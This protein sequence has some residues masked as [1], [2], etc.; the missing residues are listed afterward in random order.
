MSVNIYDL[1]G[2]IEKKNLEKIKNFV[3]EVFKK[4]GFLSNRYD[5]S[6]VLVDDLKI[7]E[8]NNKYRNKDNPTDVLSFYLGKD[9]K[10]RII[11]EIYISIDTARV[12]ALENK[13]DLLDE[14][15]FLSLHGVLHILGFDH[16]TEED[17][18]K[19]EKETAKLIV[20]WRQ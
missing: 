17:Y 5:L 18:E 10:G 20:L 13:K 8:L 6:I 16:E 15:A 19:M 4:E 2:G 3:K 1:Y 12:Q 14:L 9:P 7:R 11:G